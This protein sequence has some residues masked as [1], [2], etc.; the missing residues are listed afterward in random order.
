MGNLKKFNDFIIKEERDWDDEHK[1]DDDDY[2]NDPPPEMEDEVE[3]EDDEVDFQSE[4]DYLCQTI[5]SLFH[6]SQINCNVI[7]NDLDLLVYIFP[8]EKE[9]LR[10]LTKI[11]DV[12]NKLKRDILPQ[13][14]SEF[15]VYQQKDG[16]SVILFTFEYDES[17]VSKSS[18]D[19]FQIIRGDSRK[20]WKS[21]TF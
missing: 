13:Y 20:A 16:T 4:M 12:A 21:R 18:D 5:E 10:S 2:K 15:E 9:S 7:N 14:S 1:Y 6:N 11:F 8:E 19:N 17:E 3:S